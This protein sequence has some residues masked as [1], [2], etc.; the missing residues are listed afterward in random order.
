MEF[1]FLFFAFICGLSVKM[2]GVPPLVG[3]LVAGFVLNAMGYG[4]T[5]QLQSIADLGITIMLF[6]IGLKLNIKDLSK[7]EVWF[8][9]VSHTLLWVGICLFSFFR[10]T[11]VRKRIAYRICPQ[12]QQHGL[13]Y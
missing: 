5:G 11:F 10:P 6:T 1:L 3:Y 9:S 13:C 12:F 2:A 4:M 8:G 7:P